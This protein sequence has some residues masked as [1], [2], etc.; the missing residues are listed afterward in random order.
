MVKMSISTKVREGSCEGNT[1]LDS[2]NFSQKIHKPF[3]N[4][5]GA[6]ILTDAPN[7]K[8]HLNITVTEASGTR[9]VLARMVTMLAL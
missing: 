5:H 9:E 4:R 6:P 8:G 2:K 3:R 1:S 7:H